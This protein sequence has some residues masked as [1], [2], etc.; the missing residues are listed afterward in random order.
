[1][2]NWEYSM[3]AQSDGTWVSWIK[4]DGTIDQQKSEVGGTGWIIR[5]NELAQDGWE[6]AGLITTIGTAILLKRAVR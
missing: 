3:L 6:V 2:S 4:P 5:L 1:M